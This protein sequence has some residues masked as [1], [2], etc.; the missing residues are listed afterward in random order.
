M[1]QSIWSP[2]ILCSL[3]FGGSLDFIGFLLVAKIWHMI[4][5]S[6][7]GMFVH[8]SNALA[9][10]RLFSHLKL[11]HCFFSRLCITFL[12]FDV[13][14]VVICVAVACLVG[15]AV[16]CCLPCIIAILYA[17]ADQ[18]MFTLILCYGERL[19]KIKLQWMSHGFAARSFYKD[20]SIIYN[21][22][23]ETWFCSSEKCK[24]KDKNVFQGCK[25]RMSGYKL[26]LK[27][28]LRTEMSS[29]WI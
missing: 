7:T 3:L 18:V 17:V 11:H 22:V 5:L 24:V 16:C 28:S 8:L 27:S 19:L 13:F 23:T 25:Y 29:L 14:F 9:I 15:L 20:K 12:A 26:D 4:H 2:Q 10:Q 1:S 6:S 21:V